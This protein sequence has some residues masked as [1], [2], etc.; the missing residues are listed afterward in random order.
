VAMGGAIPIIAGVVIGTPIVIVG[1]VLGALLALGVA[2]RGR[3]RG[4]G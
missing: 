4:T 2:I 1:A 3:E